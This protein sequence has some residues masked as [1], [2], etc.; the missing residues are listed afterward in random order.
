VG[1]QM[2]SEQGA[3]AAVLE[4]AMSA[5]LATLG[6]SA[7]GGEG[8]GPQLPSKQ[9]ASAPVLEAAIS[10]RLATLGWSAAEGREHA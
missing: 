2:H 10:A 1:P 4:A 3:S 6:W 5:R 9:G 7:G 8:G